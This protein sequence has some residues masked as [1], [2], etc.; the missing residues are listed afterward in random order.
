MSLSIY[1][2]C[3][4]IGGNNNFLARF[5]I[6][7]YVLYHGTNCKEYDKSPPPFSQYS[8]IRKIQ[9]IGCCFKRAICISLKLKFDF[10][11]WLFYEIFYGYIK[12]EKEKEKECDQ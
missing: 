11:I 10:F 4:T 3:I 12:K 8:L 7:W 1:W 9:K 6:T 2:K 5:Y